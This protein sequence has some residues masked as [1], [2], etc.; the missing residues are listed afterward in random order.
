[1]KALFT[2]VIFIFCV[3]LYSQTSTEK[4]NSVSDRFET[5]NSN[6]DMISYKTYNSIKGQWET[7][8]VNDKSDGVYHPQSSVNTDLMQR[9][10]QSKQNR[11][12]ANKERITAMLNLCYV[13]I[14]Q[15]IDSKTNYTIY[16]RVYN[17][18]TNEYVTPLNNKSYDFS[19]TVLTDNII[20]WLDTGLKTIF[21]QEL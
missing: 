11:F 17:R 2:L 15:K 21:S 5:F 16:T 19:N 1:M 13:T 10:L 9:A 6:G 8:S 20:N 7:Y 4:Y 18:F 14:Y 12:D 3:S